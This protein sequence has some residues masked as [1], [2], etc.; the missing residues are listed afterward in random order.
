MKKPNVIAIVGPTAS[1][2]TAISIE[3]AKHFNGEIISADSRQ[4]Y[5]GLDIGTSKVTT[6]E[7]RGIPHHLIDIIEPTEKY[8]GVDFVN[9]ATMEITNIINRQHTPIIAGGTF[10]YL[11]L[12]RGK[13]QSAP[14]PI[15]KSLR[16]EL[17]TLS[18][19]ELLTQLQKSDPDRASTIDT[20]NRRR[21]IRSLEII[22]SLGKVP[23]VTP[24]ESPYN[25][26]IIGLTVGKEQ[27]RS[28]YKQRLSEWL[29]RG[30]QTEIEKLLKTGISKEQFHELGFE[31]ILMLSYIEK[32]ITL[33]ELQEKFVQKNWQYAK[34]Q[35]S[36]LKRDNDIA[37][38]KPEE[39]TA[40]IQHVKT[41]ITS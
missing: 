9:D 10:F 40:I 30:F 32:D 18:T 23:K 8:T 13:Q 26:L 12:L 33:K 39:N 38:F 5:K 3:I 37:W 24:I 21:I 2:K 29:D 16:D 14:V 31:Y 34:R 1:G 17:E 11:D 25:W 41:F 36:W 15:N 4:I 19:E 22:E 28:Y 7:M 20:Q 6:E 35:L 27:L